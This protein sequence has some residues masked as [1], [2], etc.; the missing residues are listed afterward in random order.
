MTT[1]YL[2]IGMK[3]KQQRTPVDVF[4]DVSDIV[5]TFE[6][7][8]VSVQRSAAVATATPNNYGHRRRV[9]LIFGDVTA[10][11]GTAR[12]TSVAAALY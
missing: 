2:L 9:N 6:V 4:L 8:N 12:R 5:D 7:D 3:F 1:L 10:R 11:R